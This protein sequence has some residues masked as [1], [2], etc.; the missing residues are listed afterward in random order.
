LIRMTVEADN[1]NKCLF[2]AGLHFLC[3]GGIATALAVLLIKGAVSLM[4]Y[5][6]Y[7]AIS[8]GAIVVPFAYMKR[9]NWARLMLAGESVLLVLGSVGVGI[10]LAH[11]Y[12]AIA[13]GIVILC[14]VLIW[15]ASAKA[16]VAP[17]TRYM[18]R[19]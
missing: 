9:M 14:G 16:L 8:L 5:A 4:P 15:G 3:A 13:G 7:L 2:I 11:V 19:K 1:E 6:L 10:Y 18:F 12:T 17:S